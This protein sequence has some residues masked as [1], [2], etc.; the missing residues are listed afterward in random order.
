[1][2]GTH[3]QL[4]K[5]RMYRIHMDACVGQCLLVYVR[6]QVHL[7]MRSCVHAQLIW[8]ASYTKCKP[9][10]NSQNVCLSLTAAGHC[11]VELPHKP[12]I[13]CVL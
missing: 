3:L 13:E 11:F 7:C 1:M 12:V 4:C 6:H 2:Q 9:H 10:E 8:Q 5:L